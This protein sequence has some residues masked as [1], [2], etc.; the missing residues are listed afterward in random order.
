M[1]QLSE[2][3]RV[4]LMTR[5]LKSWLKTTQGATAVSKTDPTH[6]VLSI[7]LSTSM[8]FQA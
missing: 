4:K 6:I 2:G 7:Q 1:R 8:G 5:K 3:N